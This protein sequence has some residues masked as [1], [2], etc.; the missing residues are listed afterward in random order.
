MLGNYLPSG[1]TLCAPQDPLSRATYL[2]FDYPVSGPI[3]RRNEVVP[4][5]DREHVYVQGL[6]IE[7]PLNTLKTS[8]KVTLITHEQ[9]TLIGQTPVLA[10]AE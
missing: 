5:A 7:P 10:P 8:P 4:T 1:R 6:P 9:D 2:A 3:R